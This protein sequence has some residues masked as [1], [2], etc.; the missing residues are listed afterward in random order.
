MLSYTA[1][2]I[3]GIKREKKMEEKSIKE[4]VGAT[5]EEFKDLNRHEMK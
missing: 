5:F 4:L 2:K 3:I 1:S